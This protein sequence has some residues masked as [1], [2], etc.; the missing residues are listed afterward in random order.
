M[1]SANII[2]MDRYTLDTGNYVLYDNVIKVSLATPSNNDTYVV[3]MEYPKSDPTLKIW[4]VEH[5]SSVLDPIARYFK[6]ING[7]KKVESPYPG[8]IGVTTGVYAPYPPIVTFSAGDLIIYAGAVSDKT[9]IIVS[10]KDINS[11]SYLLKNLRVLTNVQA[12]VWIT[13]NLAKDLNGN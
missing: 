7:T 9:D 13:S 6:F 11:A 1:A 4:I 5:N 2:P 12:S 8:L 10:T 3:K